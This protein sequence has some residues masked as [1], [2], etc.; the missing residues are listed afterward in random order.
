MAW[1]DFPDWF[2]RRRRSPLFSG[3]FFDDIDQMMEDMLREMGESIPKELVRDE[4]LPDGSTVKR[5]GP[6]VYGYSMTMGPDGKPVIREFGNI[7]Q[8][9]TSAFGMPKRGLEVKAEREPLVDTFD[10]NGTVKIVAEVPGIEKK[11]INLEL[12]ENSLIIS[13]DTEKRK[14]F[15]EVELPT[16]IEP[17]STKALYVNGVLEVTLEKRSKK[18]SGHKIDVK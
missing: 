17:D 2:R 9:R 12:T 5:M 7:K 10:E 16:Q 18:P 8:T 11:D 14:Y 15:K 13:V 4:K 1:D 6:F 3:G